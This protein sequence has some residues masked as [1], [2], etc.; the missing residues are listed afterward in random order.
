MRIVNPYLSGLLHWQL[1]SPPSLNGIGKIGH[2]HWSSHHERYETI[3]SY[4]SVF[5]NPL[6]SCELQDK[7]RWHTNQATE[8]HKR[9]FCERIR[10]CITFLFSYDL[11]FANKD[12]FGH[13]YAACF[14]GPYRYTNYNSISLSSIFIYMYMTYNYTKTIT[15]VM[16]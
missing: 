3:L 1:T 8:C 16:K 12:K 14:Y 2:R 11:V 5:P 13:P 9:L 6:I 10:I 15:D 7:D 4:F